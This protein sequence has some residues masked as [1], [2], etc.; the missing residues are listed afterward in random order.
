MQEISTN[1]QQ[2][3][4]P[5]DTSLSQPPTVVPFAS[6]NGT[7][8]HTASFDKQPTITER[9][10]TGPSEPSYSLRN[11]ATRLEGPKLAATRDSMRSSKLARSVANYVALAG[12]VS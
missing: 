9:E 4:Q 2:A 1:I 11:R 3:A 8:K 12:E 10:A 5:A 6:S 7:S